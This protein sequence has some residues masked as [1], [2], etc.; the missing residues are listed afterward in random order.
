MSDMHHYDEHLC[1]DHDRC[2]QFN[3]EGDT[4]K[5]HHHG[6]NDDDILIHSHDRDDRPHTHGVTGWIRNRW[7]TAYRWSDHTHPE[8]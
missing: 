2:E 8:E 4:D 7:T 5:H 6:P 3:H 1:G